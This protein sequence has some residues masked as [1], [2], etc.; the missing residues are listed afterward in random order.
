MD[1]RSAL[2]GL[3]PER[4]VEVLAERSDRALA[5]GRHGDLERW[6]SAL[7][8]LPDVGN[9]WSVLDG[10]LVAGDAAGDPAAL[11]V[12]LGEFVPWR[13]G[14]LVL[15]GVA[16]DTEWRSDWKWERVRGAVDLRGKRVL[17]IG[18]GNGYFSWRM[19]DDGAAGVLACDP[20]AVFAMQ[21]EAIRHFAGG[22][23]PVLLP[24]R[25]EELD[26]AGT[27][28][29][30]FSM[31]VLYHRRDPAEHLDRIRRHLPAGG[32]VVLETLVIP[33]E[34]DEELDP[35]DRY[36]N[37]RNVHRLPTESRLHRWL[38]E[39]GFDEVRTL[40]RTVTT[41]EEQRPTAWMPFHSLPHALDADG[42]RTVEGLPRP[43]R[44]A[45]V[46]RRDG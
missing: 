3:V 30:V 36:A 45:V 7:D 39:V 24:L 37:M 11:A 34:R 19:L 44:I 6:R 9:G 46:A 22:E 8:A 2:A 1:Y 25:F 43:E 29:A 13:K 15:G 20:T 4:A 42:V 18:A 32:T 16:I 10:R 5:P 28:D 17:D 27:F 14:P 21:F 23:G 35:P 40:D 33:G 12:T 41:A 31:G 38:A 26:A